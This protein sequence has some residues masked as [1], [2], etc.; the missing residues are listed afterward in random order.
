MSLLALSVATLVGSSLI[1]ALILYGAYQDTQKVGT[2][3]LPLYKWCS[4]KYLLEALPVTFLFGASWVG[5]CLGADSGAVVST[6][7]KGVSVEIPVRSVL[8]TQVLI[9]GLGI[10]ATV[11]YG[12]TELLWNQSENKF[13]PLIVAATSNCYC[14]YCGG[15]VVQDKPLGGY[16][17]VCSAAPDAQC[18][19]NRHERHATTGDP[20][21]SKK[22]GG[23]GSR[24]FQGSRR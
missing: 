19:P 12:L 14:T 10:F 13:S 3:L 1:L 23:A 16:C 5:L 4:A 2:A 8:V 15:R 7:I 20:L 11:C 21:P 18:D 17:P 24:H 9:G 22:K 6:I